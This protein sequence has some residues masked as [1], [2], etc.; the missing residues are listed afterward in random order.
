VADIEVASGLEAGDTVVV[1]SYKAIRTMRNGARVK[2]D[3]RAG[4]TDSKSQ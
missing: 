1:G 2:V 3:N 4:I